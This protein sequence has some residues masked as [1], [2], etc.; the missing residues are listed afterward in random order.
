MKRQMKS[1]TTKTADPQP[2]VQRGVRR[3]WL[4]VLPMAAAAAAVLLAVSVAAPFEFVVGTNGASLRRGTL[5]LI[6]ATCPISAARGAWTF[7]LSGSNGTVLLGPM[8]GWRPHTS[9]GRMTVG[10]S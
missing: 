6:H 1:P 5:Q 9:T 3:R 10:P 4:W 7:Q 2:M 8:N